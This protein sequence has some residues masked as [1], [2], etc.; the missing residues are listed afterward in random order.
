M[1][2]ER[3]SQ[4]N[5]PAYRSPEWFAALL[6]LEQHSGEWFECRLGAVTGSRVKDAL[7]VLKRASNGSV[8]GD[9]SQASKDYMMELAL[10]RLTGIIPDHYVTPAMDWGITH[11]SDAVQ[12]YEAITGNPCRKV[13][14]A[15][16]RTIEM[17][18]ASSDRYVHGGGILE[19]KCPTSTVHVDYI[20][21][22]A[23]PEQY[24]PQCL[25]ELACDPEREWLDFV[26][27]DPRFTGPAIKLA[28]FIAPRMYRQHWTK[29][30]AELEDGV[31]KF[32]AETAAL[33]AELLELA[34]K[35][36]F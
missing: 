31:Y 23:V 30:I 18:Y 34:E 19:A 15:A 25:A 4:V 35:R 2:R 22:N 7:S 1:G 24:L 9:R 26:S 6:K 33:T 13:G 12:A 36:K 27:F 17:F 3:E 14:L 11:E 5:L 10:G 32:L 29:Q 16:H 20:K 21:G 8:A 28:V